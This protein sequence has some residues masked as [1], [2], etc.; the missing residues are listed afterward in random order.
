MFKP[1]RDIKK[2]PILLISILFFLTGSSLC[3]A[4]KIYYKDGKAITAAILYRNKDTVWVKYMSG[5]FGVNVTDIDRIENEDGSISKYDYE[6]ILNLVQAYIRQKKY[7]EAATSLNLLVESSPDNTQLHYLRAM[8]NQKAGDLK[9]AVNDYNF[10][11]EHRAADEQVFNNMGAI[12]AN[13]KEYK[14]AMDLFVQ[15]AAKAPDAVEVHDNLAQLFMRTGDYSRARDEYNIVVSSEPKNTT[16]LYNLGVAYMN[17][18]DYAKAKEQWEKILA[19]APQND[20]VKN[21]LEYLKAKSGNTA[22]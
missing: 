2:T 13:D 20:D 12:Y 5:S 4:E 10:L 17:I 22:K 6:S 18:A 9:A 19:I 8:L 16:A 21:A 11:L 7:N 1:H 15:A 14:Q 3:N